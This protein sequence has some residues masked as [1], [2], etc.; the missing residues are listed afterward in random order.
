MECKRN[1]CKNKGDYPLQKYEGFCSIH[2]ADLHYGDEEITAL[3]AELKQVKEERDEYEGKYRGIMEFVM[4]MAPHRVQH[5]S[6]EGCDAWRKDIE[7][8]KAVTK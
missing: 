8:A 7:E 2:C 6:C 3:K 4:H 5:C 1:G